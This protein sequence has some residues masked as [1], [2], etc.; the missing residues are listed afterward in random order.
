MKTACLALVGALLL[1]AWAPARVPVLFD[2]DLGAEIDDAFA[3]ALLLASPEVELRGVTAVGAPTKERALLLCRFLTVTG[4]RHTPVAAG[5]GEQPARPLG[6]LHQYYY[7]PD[8]LFNR[9]RRP[10]KESA[11][12]L[13]YARLKAQPGKVTLL[14]AGPL[15]NVA[16]L[17]CEKPECKPWI[18]R[19]V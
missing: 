4:R 8:V 11:T 16:R 15:T 7:H 14:A 18:K 3:L 5:A 1:P 19:I 9:T 10:E 6:A 17:L 13:L 2:T 12:Q